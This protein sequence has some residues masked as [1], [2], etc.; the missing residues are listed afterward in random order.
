VGARTPCSACHDSHGISRTQG[1]A[2]TNSN[3]I[4]FD[5]SIVRPASGGL[6]SRILFED[7]GTYSGSCT[8]TC[9]GVVHVNF[10]YGR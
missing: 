5:L 2:R 10:E 1:T 3:L 7:R 9:H 6:G 8:L 4:N